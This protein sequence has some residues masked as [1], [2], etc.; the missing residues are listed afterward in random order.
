MN[1]IFKFRLKAKSIFKPGGYRIFTWFAWI[2]TPIFLLSGCGVNAWLCKNPSL[3][4]NSPSVEL[5]DENISENLKPVIDEFRISIARNMK[6]HNIAGLAIAVVDRESV[7]R[8]AG[9]SV[10]DRRSGEPVTFETAFSIQS[11]SKHLT[12]TAVMLEV[13][14]R[15]LDLDATISDYLTDF[16]VN[17]RFEEAPERKITLRQLLTHKAGFTQEASVG[18]N[19]VATSSSFGAHGASISDTWLKFPVGER[20]SYSNLGID[21]AGYILQQQSSLPFEDYMHKSL[22][23]PLG[24]TTSFVDKAGQTLCSNCAIGHAKYF[25]RFPDYV[26][27]AAAGGFA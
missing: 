23:N 21:I 26:P 18:N 8:K 27:M 11:I 13:Q 22:F 24:L 12:A 9:F 25:V 14:K 10:R 3:A 1:E 6:E 7:L 15:R 4:T 5:V 17:S 2:F 16:T 19:S 20:F